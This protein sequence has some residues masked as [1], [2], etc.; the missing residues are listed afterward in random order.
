MALQKA[1]CLIIYILW[2]DSELSLKNTTFETS[3]GGVSFLKGCLRHLVFRSASFYFSLCGKKPANFSVAC[4]WSHCTGAPSFLWEPP[5]ESSG[6]PCETSCHQRDCRPRW[7][8]ALVS[9]CPVLL[10]LSSGMSCRFWLI[11]FVFSAGFCGPHSGWEIVDRDRNELENVIQFMVCLVCKS[12]TIMN[13]EGLNK[14]VCDC[15]IPN[16]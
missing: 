4:S 2:E 1:I 10:A 15:R 7:W 14:L 3:G 8:R 12:R 11:I 6:I 13:F 5:G 16:F 9:R